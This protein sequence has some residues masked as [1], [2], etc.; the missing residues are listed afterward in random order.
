M[1]TFVRFAALVFIATLVLSACVAIPADHTSPAISDVSTSGKVLV[2][3]DCLATSV[4]VTAQVTDAS[5]ITNVLLW[6]R[7]GSDQPYASTNMNPQGGLYTASVKGS[8]LQ[9]GGYGTLEF[10]IT[11]EDEAG[12][13]GQSPPDKSIQFLPCVNS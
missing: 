4:T 1:R 3:S 8:D 9:G 5:R 12:N 13:H 2:I 6:Y 10:Y 11:A 7:I